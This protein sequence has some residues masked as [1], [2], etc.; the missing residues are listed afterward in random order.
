MIH[1]CTERNSIFNS[2]A[3]VGCIYLMGSQASL[4]FKASSHSWSLQLS[5]QIFLILLAIL[6]IQTCANRLID[7]H[8]TERYEGP[9]DQTDNVLP[10]FNL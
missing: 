10:Y 7:K 8:E 6:L 3:T 5:L 9:D 4:T 2:K 1:R